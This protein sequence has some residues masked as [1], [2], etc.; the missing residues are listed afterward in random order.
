MT[1]GPAPFSLIVFK[2]HLLL[3]ALWGGLE[4]P[5]PG[6]F[7]FDPILGG[8]CYSDSAGQPSAA[9]VLAEQQPSTWGRGDRGQGHVQR[10][11]RLCS[12]WEHRDN[13]PHLLVPV[14]ALTQLG[15]LCRL[16]AEVC[17]PC[18]RALPLVE[19]RSCCSGTVTPCRQRRWRAQ[20]PRTRG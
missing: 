6:M 4:E 1:A 20:F 5:I 14:T 7:L 17:H 12:R 3:P 19:H 15:D 18:R 8:L 11:A 16:R 2:S 13:T 9:L 10:K